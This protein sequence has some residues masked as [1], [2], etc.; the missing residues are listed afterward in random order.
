M[1]IANTPAHSFENLPGYDFSG[2]Y[3][4]VEKDLSVH[5]LDEGPADGEVVLCM[6]GEPSWS[7]LY[8]K[9]IPVFAAVGYRVLAPD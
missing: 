4:E 2:K 5:F 1:D 9:I 3:F 7:Y 6:H 8:R